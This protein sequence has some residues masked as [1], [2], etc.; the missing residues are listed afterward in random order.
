M[1]PSL[2][3]KWASGP[4]FASP[5]NPEMCT[6][7]QFFLSVPH[8]AENSLKLK[9]SHLGN[10]IAC[11]F[12]EARSKFVKNTYF[13][14]R[15][16]KKA[17]QLKKEM[18]AQKLPNA[19]SRYKKWDPRMLISQSQRATLCTTI[20]S[21]G[22]SACSWDFLRPEDQSSSRALSPK[23]PPPQHPCHTTMWKSSSSTK[24]TRAASSVR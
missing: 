10:T 21:A 16:S 18:G 23:P 12:P 24:P 4:I 3:L 15:A 1:G 8:V 5:K 19:Q 7:A 20:W 14:Q 9:G 13:K 17:T 22:N 2:I 11:T 6:G